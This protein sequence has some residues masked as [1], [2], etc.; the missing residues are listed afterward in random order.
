MQPLVIYFNEKSLLGN[1]P[2]SLWESGAFDIF[3][4]LSELL[5]IR[6]DCEIAFLD[7]NWDSICVYRCTKVS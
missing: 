6:P 1:L 5:K 4:L 3:H 2:P 7:G